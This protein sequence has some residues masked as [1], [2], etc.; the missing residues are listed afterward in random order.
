MTRNDTAKLHLRHMIGGHAR[1]PDER[2]YRFVF[3]ERPGALPT[4]LAAMGKRWNITLFHYRNHGA[5]YARVLVGMTLP[6]GEE[7]QMDEFIKG[8]GYKAEEESD[9]EAYSLFL[10]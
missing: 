8:L 6:K 3:P 5:A 7:T 9:N 2:L 4:F 1:L 10:R